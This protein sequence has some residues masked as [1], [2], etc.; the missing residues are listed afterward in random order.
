[1]IEARSAD[2]SV[3][4]T[5]S[6]AKA[7]IEGHD[8]DSAVQVYSQL[9]KA[10]LVAPLRGE[11]MTNLGAALCLLARRETGPR[12]Q[13]RLDQAHHLL[14]SALAFRSR[15]TAP[16]AWA[17]T[18]ANLAMVHLARYQAGGDRD[19]LLSGHLALDGIEQ[20]LRHTDETALRDWVAAIRDQLIDLRERRHRKRG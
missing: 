13:A 11:V 5:L 6:R 20:A 10:E 9:L 16:A 1:M 19:E 7:L 8:F 4:A 17:T 2:E 3:L 18:R 12:A 14:V 15:T